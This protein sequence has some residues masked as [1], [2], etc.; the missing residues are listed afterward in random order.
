MRTLTVCRGGKFSQTFR[1]RPSATCS[2]R[3]TTS[4]GSISRP[5]TNDDPPAARGV[6]LPSP[7]HRGRH[8]RARAAQ[9]GRLRARRVL[10]HPLAQTTKR[11]VQPAEQRTRPPGL[12]FHRLLRGRV[13]HDTRPRQDRSDQHVRRP[14]LPGHRP[15][16]TDP[17]VQSTLARWKAPDSP[18]GNTVGALVH[19]F[20]DAIVDD[21]FPLMDHVADRVEELE[22]TIFEHFNEAAIQS[23]FGL[24]KDLLVHAP[25]RRAR[26]RRAQRAAA[27]R[28]AH[29]PAAPTWPTCRTSTTT[30]C[31]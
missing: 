16:G 22:D 7:G 18:L 27:P 31:A 4:C 3:P 23:I 13:R 2:S 15:R 1:R 8:P 29:L 30:S 28:V 9:G 20:L 17:H 24:K 6:R 10:Q 14:E 5:P 21:Y 11:P 12:L 25:D 26:A 19:A